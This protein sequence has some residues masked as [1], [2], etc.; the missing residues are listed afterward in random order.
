LG[1]RGGLYVTRWRSGRVV[2]IVPVDELRALT[3]AMRAFRAV[4]A[5]GV[6]RGRT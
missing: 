4:P 6:L 2:R 3:E 5:V 1:P